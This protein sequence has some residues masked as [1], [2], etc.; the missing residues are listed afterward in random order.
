MR[1]SGRHAHGHAASESGPSKGSKLSY[2]QST[3]AKTSDYFFE[4]SFV[5]L[6]GEQ[7]V[8]GAFAYDMCEVISALLP[9]GPLA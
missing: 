1:V 7:D 8:I 3:L 5:V 2:V 4:Q 6:I 9:H